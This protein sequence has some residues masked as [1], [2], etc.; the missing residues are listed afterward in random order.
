MHWG[1]WWPAPSTRSGRR[2]IGSTLAVSSGFV[3]VVGVFGPAAPLP[4]LHWTIALPVLMALAVVAARLTDV[5]VGLPRGGGGYSIKGITLAA[6]A[7]LLP[8]PL[9]LL[10]SAADATE[11]AWS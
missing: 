7:L 8:A 2:F 5:G 6:A 11:S 9:V 10:V 3:L 4:T 1:G